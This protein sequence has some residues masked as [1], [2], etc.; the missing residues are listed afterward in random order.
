MDLGSEL[1]SCFC[2]TPHD[3]ANMWLTNT[4]Y[5]MIHLMACFPKHLQL[6]CIYGLDDLVLPLCPGG[7]WK[8]GKALE[9]FFNN[10]EVPSQVLELEFD[11]FS[12]DFPRWFFV[13]GNLEK[14]LSGYL[15]VSPGLFSLRVGRMQLIN[16]CFCYFPGFIQ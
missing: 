10:P 13:L 6:L 1:C 15:L 3:G 7:E 2:F 14:M 16:D 11:A 8:H 12:N 9:L 4:D 5:S